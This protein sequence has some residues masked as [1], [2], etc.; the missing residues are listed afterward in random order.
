MTTDP[1]ADLRDEIAEALMRWAEGNN[2]PKYASMRRPSVVR[3]NAYARADAVLD[4]INRRT[5]AAVPV[6]SPPADRAALRDRIARAIYGAHSHIDVWDQADAHTKEVCRVEADAVL[7][8]LPPPADRAQIRRLGLM[9]DEYATGASALTDKLKRVRDLHRETCP[10]AQ[11]SVSPTAFKCGMCEVLDAP[12]APL[13]RMADEAPVAESTADKAARLGMTPAA[14][15]AA[16]HREAVDR[17]RAAVPGLYA[18]V[19]LRVEAALEQPA[20]TPPPA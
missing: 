13:R 16:S 3:Q 2:S 10:L 11:G 17:I 5:P 19:G 18:T 12:A 14:Y 6:S 7:A 1:T 15:R 4:V 20:S 8:V 9:V